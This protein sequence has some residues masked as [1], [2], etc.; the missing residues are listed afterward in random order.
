[1]YGLRMC[2]SKNCVIVHALEILPVAI[3]PLLIF[4]Y[5]RKHANAIHYFQ[6]IEETSHDI[7][8]KL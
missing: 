8:G 4:W 5:Y 6:D 7:P 1:M 3:H 2:G